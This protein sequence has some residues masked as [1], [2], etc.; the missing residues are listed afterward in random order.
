[1]DAIHVQPLR[2]LHRL[3]ETL[4]R[5]SLSPNND[6]DRIVR[7]CG[8]GFDAIAQQARSGFRGH[9]LTIE[10][11]DFNTLH[12]FEGLNP[13][14][15]NQ[16]LYRAAFSCARYS[17]QRAVIE[18]VGAIRLFA[19]SDDE[20][21]QIA[22]FRPFIPYRLQDFTGG[23]ET[24]S[25]TYNLEY[26]AN[27][28][29]CRLRIERKMRFSRVNV[30]LDDALL[31]LGLVVQLNVSGEL[32]PPTSWSSEPHEFEGQISVTAEVHARWESGDPRKAV[33]RD[34]VIQNRRRST[35]RPRIDHGCRGRILYAEIK[36]LWPTFEHKPFLKDLDQD[37]AQCQCE[38]LW[39][40]LYDRPLGIVAPMLRLSEC[41]TYRPLADEP[42]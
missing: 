35:Y 1:M 27:D 5:E 10:A 34:I 11:G 8:R 37:F 38:S 6:G 36:N 42:F 30:A 2:F 25:R 22:F 23:H 31:R 12:L 20:V 14:S 13:G 3:R 18:Q 15:R 17:N 24:S 39:W 40:R 41:L 7:S 21:R 19:V 16:A 33:I 32:T 9:G 4:Q 29:S 26:G 28:P